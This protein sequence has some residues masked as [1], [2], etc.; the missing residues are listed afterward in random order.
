MKYKTD[1]GIKLV[2]R[3]LK[4]LAKNDKKWIK[5]EDFRISEHEIWVC[6]IFNV[7]FK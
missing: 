1:I 5:I 2:E 4:G 7:N 6:Y 3:N